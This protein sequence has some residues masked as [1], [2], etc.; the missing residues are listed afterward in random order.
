MMMDNNS[1]KLGIDILEEV[2]LSDSEMDMF[3][4]EQGFSAFDLDYSDIFMEKSFTLSEDLQPTFNVVDNNSQNISIDPKEWLVMDKSS[5]RQ[6]PPRLYEFLILLLENPYYAFYA[7]Y[8][9][10]A[11]GIFQIHE[12]E[13]V[14]NLWQQ[15]KSRRSNQK[16]TDAEDYISI[17]ISL[18]Q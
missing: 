17:I 8:T 13:N 6:R 14:A 16:M 1:E 3:A 11:E 10:K 4:D 7:S 2:M 15:V 5:K 18:R 12:P 9:N